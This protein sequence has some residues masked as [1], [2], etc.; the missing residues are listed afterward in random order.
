MRQ[1]PIS[2]PLHDTACGIDRVGEPD[3]ALKDAAFYTVVSGA[4][5]KVSHYMRTI[6]VDGAFGILKLKGE[7]G[8][9]VE[10]EAISAH[11]T[12]PSMHKMDDKHYAA[13]L[14]V[15]HKPKGAID[16]VNEGVIVSVLFDDTNGS[17][18][19]LFAHFGFPAD[20]TPS[21]GKKWPQPHY[22]DLAEALSEALEGS[23]YQYDGSVPVPPCHETI[24]YFVLGQVQPILTTQAKAVEEV[25]G[26][27]GGGMLKRTVV[28]GHGGNCRTVKKDDLVIGGP[29]HGPTCE[30]AVASHTSYRL[31]ACWDYGMSEAERAS[32]VQSPID[33]M[34]SM[35]STAESTKPQFNLRPIKSARL[36]PGNYSLEAYPLEIGAPAPL[37][38]FGTIMILGKKYMVRKISVKP[39]S[40]HTYGDERYVGE[41]QIE[42]LVF[43]DEIS[44]AAQGKG[45][46]AAGHAD[47]HSDA[48][49]SASHRRLQH[50]EGPGHTTAHAHDDGDQTHRVVVL[51]PIK[52]GVESSLLRELG[53]PFQAYREAI[54]DQHEYRIEQTIDLQAGITP[55]LEGDWLF[56][57]GGLVQPGCPKWGVRWIA[58]T[59]PITASLLQ[60]NY[61][62]LAVSG[63]DSTRMHPVEMSPQ[64]YSTKVFLNGLPS[65]SL[66]W[67]SWPCGNEPWNYD[68]VHCWA[69][70]YP[71]CG[72]GKKQ[73][74]INILPSDVQ[75]EGSSSFLHRV[76][77]KPVK[78]LRI[79]NNGHSLQ[80]TSDMLGYIQLI[81]EDGFP[82]FYDVGQ[83]HLHMP[84]EH[85]IN[86]RQFAAELHIVHTR[87][88]YV[89]TSPESHDAFP[90]VVLGF[91]FDI[92][93]HENLFLKQFF[94]GEE[95]IPNGTYK[96][97]RKPID[98]MRSLGPAL[99]GNFYRYDGSFTTPDCHEDLK[100]FVFEHVFSMS[101]AQW[102]TFK[103]EFPFA[104]FNRPVQEVINQG[105]VKNDFKEG[106]E[107]HYDFF[108]SRHLGRN[109]MRPGETYILFPV[110]ATLVLM[111]CIS[112]AV[113]VR[114]N[115]SKLESAGGLTETIGR[116]AHGRI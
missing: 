4:D 54:K 57:S 109:R 7:S 5:V 98:L 75:M 80:V 107:V 101:L 87:Q 115:R 74:P 73:S 55:S 86:G 37:P 110:I 27:W 1:S 17:E 29:H 18:S 113:F 49:H 62:A 21:P 94:L 65:W 97:A 69:E 67:H 43:G 40:S 108:L 70:Q 39:I 79:A 78:E 23:S 26:C 48:G 59:T 95:I 52:L 3:G 92:G 104:H 100:W 41:V 96:T 89:G 85:M 68:D 47:D 82:E 11:I 31:A 56:Y 81:G 8:E 9:E 24:K 46:T 84:S 114:E 35:A 83:F 116:A 63:T 16:M 102:E 103:V 36:K 105:V 22:I 112:L 10:Y 111:T 60:M 33:I 6:H 93:E 51:V 66:S 15:L 44:T 42:A 13:E 32:C 45:G 77:W 38:N 20:G 19:H 90:L 2:I 76:D 53:L 50:E 28:G 25:L 88:R 106:T 58:F 64:D 91:M 99:D 71:V 61:L 34:P 72:T 12:A 14:L 30:A